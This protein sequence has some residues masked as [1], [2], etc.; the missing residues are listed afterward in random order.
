[1]LA[2]EHR[3]EVGAGLHVELRGKDRG[4]RLEA[5]VGRLGGEGHLLAGDVRDLGDAAVRM[6]DD[7]HLVAERAVLGRHDGERA[8]ARAVHRQWVG[9]GVEARDVQAPRAH[10]LDLG[11]VVLHRE[12]L[13]VLAGN[14]FQMREE[15][16]PRSL[17]DGR[18]LDRRVGED[19]RVRI[20][21][22]GRV[23]GDVGDQVA[24]GVAVARVEVAARTVLRLGGAGEH[25]QRER[26][27]AGEQQVLGGGHGSVLPL[28]DRGAARAPPGAFTVTGARCG[29]VTVSCH[30]CLA[31][32]H[33]QRSD[34]KCVFR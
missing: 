12:E 15:V 9:P 22:V 25:G 5:R 28:R 13:H 2:R 11:R 21:L 26:A 7:L 19:E 17:V 4:R 6:G 1:M 29:P 3:L 10:R 30:A 34:E 18:I 31:S 20:D 24:V 16:G 14:L 32:A 27:R 33:P 23:L 8:E